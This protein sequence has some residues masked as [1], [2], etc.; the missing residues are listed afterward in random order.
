MKDRNLRQI[1]DNEIEEL[2]ESIYNGTQSQQK[3]IFNRI[4]E[5]YFDLDSI[6]IC[7]GLE[8]KIFCKNLSFSDIKSNDLDK[9][10]FMNKTLIYKL[11]SNP[12]MNFY[13]FGND[14]KAIYIKFIFKNSDILIRNSFSYDGSFFQSYIDQE[15][16]YLDNKDSISVFKKEFNDPKFRSKFKDYVQISN[17]PIRYK[18][19][20]E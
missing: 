1:N 8:K 13:I 20:K 18:R 11:I 17:W 6:I 10:K 12:N 15:I 7:R 14:G 4:N 2:T 19:H 3:S 5:S 16:V 9:N